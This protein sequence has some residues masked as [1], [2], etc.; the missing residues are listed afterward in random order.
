M[1]LK[2]VRRLPKDLYLKLNRIL[3]RFF[4]PVLI[5]LHIPETVFTQ[6]YIWPILSAWIVFFGSLLF[7]FIMKK[8]KS[9]DQYSLGALTVTA[10]IGSISFVGFPI[11]EMLYGAE[12][13][14]IGIIM[15]TLGTFVICV[16]AGVLVSSWFASKKPNPKSILVP[17]LKFPPFIAFVVALILNLCSYQHPEWFRYI[18]VIVNSIFPFLA[19]ITIGLAINFSFKEVRDPHLLLGLSYKLLIAP[20]LIFLLFYF[21]IGK[22]DTTAKICVL[23]AGIGSMNTIAIIAMELGLNPSLCSKMVGIGIPLSIPL[24]FVINLLLSI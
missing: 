14:K 17:M 5:V 8:W 13:L 11:F 3:I 24:L 9:I 16:T 2:K 22:I 4:I 18:L 20:M 7:F 15:S 1:L 23:A 12:G 10:G 6:N 21:F 19:L